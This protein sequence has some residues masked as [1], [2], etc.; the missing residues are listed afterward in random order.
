MVG[1][2]GYIATLYKMEDKCELI[3]A[4]LTVMMIVIL[5]YCSSI[6]YWMR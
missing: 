6:S 1:Y 2:D 4:I 3:L 5:R